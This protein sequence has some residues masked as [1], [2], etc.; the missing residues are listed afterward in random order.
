MCRCNDAVKTFLPDVEDE[1]AFL[2]LEA[3]TKKL[4]CLEAKLDYIES[5]LSGV[6]AE[7]PS[8]D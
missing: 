5:M 4:A 7:E 1:A 6:P 8:H 2:V 3:L